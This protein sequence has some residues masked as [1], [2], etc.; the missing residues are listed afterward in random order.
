MTL[1]DRVDGKI[2]N[3]S[4]TKTRPILKE[5]GKED[6]KNTKSFLLRKG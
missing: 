4:S 2:N 5:E 3:V 1:G 6:A